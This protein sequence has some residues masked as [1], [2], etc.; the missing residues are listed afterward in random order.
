[1]TV[2]ELLEQK[3]IENRTLWLRNTSAEYL[4]FLL[5]KQEFYAMQNEDVPVSEDAWKV[6]T[7]TEGF[8]V[9]ELKITKQEDLNNGI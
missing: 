1:M 7:V 9:E 6:L 3:Y 4:A 5:A 2:Q 8:L